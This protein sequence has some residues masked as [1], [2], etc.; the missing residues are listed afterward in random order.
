MNIFQYRYFKLISHS[1]DMRPPHRSPIYTQSDIHTSR[2]THGIVPSVVLARFPIPWH[3]AIHSATGFYLGKLMIKPRYRNSERDLPPAMASGLSPLPPLAG[4]VGQNLRLSRRS[5]AA[6]RLH[7]ISRRRGRGR[8]FAWL[9]VLGFFIGSLFFVFDFEVLWVFLFRLVYIF[10]S[11]WSDLCMLAVYIDFFG[12]SFTCFFP[13]PLVIQH[14]RFL[15]LFIHFLNLRLSP[16][17]ICI[18]LPCLFLLSFP[19]PP[20]TLLRE[21]VNPQPRSSPN[22]DLAIYCLRSR[23]FSVTLQNWDI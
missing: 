18:S 21:S 3:K 6:V 11:V 17:M 2:Y 15:L 8:W 23:V 19:F 4:V 13:F 10:L 20:P 5:L 12:V 22:A 16:G 14:V 9:R 7:P 1:N